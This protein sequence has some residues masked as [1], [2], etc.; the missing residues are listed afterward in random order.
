MRDVNLGNWAVTPHHTYFMHVH[1]APD[2]SAVGLSLVQIGDGSEPCI[3]LDSH[4]GDKY[5]GHVLIAAGK[6]V[7]N[8]EV[9]YFN[10]KQFI[11][12]TLTDRLGRHSVRLPPGCYQ[13]RF[14]YAGE[15]REFEI[16]VKPGHLL[17]WEDIGAS[18]E[19]LDAKERQVKFITEEI[20][21]N[22]DNSDGSPF[23]WLDVVEVICKIADRIGQAE[24]TL[25]QV[26]FAQFCRPDIIEHLK[27]RG[28]WA[29]ETNW[30]D[31]QFAGAYRNFRSIQ[32]ARL[33]RLKRHDEANYQFTRNIILDEAGKRLDAPEGGLNYL[34]L[35]RIAAVY[36][37]ST[38]SGAIGNALAVYDP[39]SDGQLGTSGRTT[40]NPVQSVFNPHSMLPQGF[41]GPNA[42]VLEQQWNPK[43]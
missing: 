17:K 26:S 11:A 30:R 20:V 3:G 19:I 14:V 27:M 12:E 37:A 32:A 29:T 2:A 39:M 18:G 33:V 38:L 28:C 4:E 25:R 36:H 23:E 13:Y 21:C 42:K 31:L 8:V 10:D 35:A 6:P 34:A 43:A 16:I 22:W 5:G 40:Q 9:Q 41:G 15:S 7:P 1:N 24:G